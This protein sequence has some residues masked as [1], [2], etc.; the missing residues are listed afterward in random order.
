MWHLILHIMNHLLLEI[1]IVSFS[2]IFF[3]FLLFLLHF[4]FFFFV[5]G[6]FCPCCIE[7]ILQVCSIHLLQ[8]LHVA[9]WVEK[10]MIGLKT[11]HVVCF[12]PIRRQLMRG[13]VA[14]FLFFLKK[15]V[16]KLL[17]LLM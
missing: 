16:V 15:F 4:F 7:F 17:A 12:E 9:R 3:P 8:V 14:V 5:I 1:R 6:F 10:N 11:N 13:Y 2:P